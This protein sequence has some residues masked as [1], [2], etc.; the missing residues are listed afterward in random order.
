MKN[1]VKLF[2]VVGVLA[3][4]LVLWVLLAR[5]PSPAPQP[6]PLPSPS[7]APVSEAKKK[8]SPGADSALIRGGGSTAVL[9]DVDS[10]S[11]RTVIKVRPNTLKIE[12][13]VYGL[14]RK[15]EWVE[16]HMNGDEGSTDQPEDLIG[17][18]LISGDAARKKLHFAPASPSENVTTFPDCI[19]EEGAKLHEGTKSYISDFDR[20]IYLSTWV[21][22]QYSPADRKAK[23][24]VIHRVDQVQ[25]DGVCTPLMKKEKKREIVEQ[26]NEENCFI[27]EQ[28]AASASL[29]NDVIGM[30]KN[31]ISP[32]HEYWLLLN[33]RQGERRY[34]WLLQLDAKYRL[35]GRHESRSNAN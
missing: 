22:A 7:P 1:S 2:G 13:P 3:L 21:E 28:V 9:A 30:A 26:L 31:A 17:G 35:I 23:C 12:A 15:G 4:G 25:D 32:K 27:A 18:L 29:A 10:S 5:A 20:K 8:P 6:A 14:N 16:I 33:A 24:R 34:T 19:H 11:G